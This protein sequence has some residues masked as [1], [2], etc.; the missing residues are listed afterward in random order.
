M[1]PSLPAARLPGLAVSS[2]NALSVNIGGGFVSTQVFHNTAW[3]GRVHNW[4][5]DDIA[6]RYGIEK[7]RWV[8][9]PVIIGWGVVDLVSLTTGEIWEVKRSTL[10]AVLGHNQI[11][12][13]TAPGARL[14]RNTING[15]PTQ[16]LQLIPGGTG[17][18]VISGNTFVR[19]TRLSTY[20]ISYWDAGGGLIQYDFARN[21]NW[22][23]VGDLMVSV[24]VVA[25]VTITVVLTKGA[26]IPVVAAV[27]T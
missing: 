7:N 2:L 15:V 19:T 9:S 13:Y 23:A 24:V 3:P 25:G 18:T 14:H 22:Q 21:T 20:T 1:F 17:G 10:P 6:A 16:N 11:A 5:V 26:A 8:N 12:R 27:G 4:V